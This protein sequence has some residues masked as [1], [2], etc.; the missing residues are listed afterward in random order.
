[1]SRH[2]N[3]HDD[4]E[5]A[6]IATRLEQLERQFTDAAIKRSIT[7]ISTT[8]PVTRGELMAAKD[9]I[10]K[11]TAEVSKAVKKM[12]WIEEALEVLALEKEGA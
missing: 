5:L 6:G 10:A 12:K 8:A 2:H 1:M 9:D 7:P 3:T 4:Y 11:L